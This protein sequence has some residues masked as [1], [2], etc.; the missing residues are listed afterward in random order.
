MLLDLLNHAPRMLK[1]LLTIQ[2]L[3]SSLPF[4]PL[5][6]GVGRDVD[7]D[8]S[9]K[10]WMHFV[11]MT[12]NKSLANLR[13]CLIKGRVYFRVTRPIGRQDNSRLSLLIEWY[14]Y[15]IWFFSVIFVSKYDIIASIKKER[16]L[17][18]HSLNGLCLTGIQNCC[19]NPK[20]IENCGRNQASGEVHG[21]LL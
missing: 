15:W 16:K 14:Y 3:C 12:S 17:D 4:R 7:G 2:S 13:L 8:G 10:N 11:R 1:Y 19:C 9:S 6:P 21:R 18:M 20:I 5:Q